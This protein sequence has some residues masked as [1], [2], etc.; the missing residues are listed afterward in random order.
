VPLSLFAAQ[1]SDFTVS[2]YHH[3]PSVMHLS[4]HQGI[5]LGQKGVYVQQLEKYFMEQVVYTFGAKKRQFFVAIKNAFVLSIIVTKTF[6]RHCSPVTLGLNTYISSTNIRRFTTIFFRVHP[7]LAEPSWIESSSR[8][9]QKGGHRKFIKLFLS[10]V[11]TLQL[12]QL[13]CSAVTF[14]MFLQCWHLKKILNPNIRLL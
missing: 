3:H 12:I 1:Y 2:E 10:Q 14:K 5:S 13:L 9:A 11:S 8:P 4:T 6:R 7:T